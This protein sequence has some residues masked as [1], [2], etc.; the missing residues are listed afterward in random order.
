MSNET[1]LI[2]DIREMRLKVY[3]PKSVTGLL[4][5]TYSAGKSE[6]KS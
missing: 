5:G 4:L 6:K 1:A 2:S 3:T